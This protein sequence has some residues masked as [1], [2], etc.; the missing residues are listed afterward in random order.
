MN[1]FAVRLFSSLP[2]LGIL[3]TAIYSCILLLR[4]DTELESR[5]KEDKE[6]IERGLIRA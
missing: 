5:K 3:L 1:R 2:H 4:L 6:F